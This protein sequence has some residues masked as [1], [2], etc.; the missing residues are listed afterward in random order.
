MEHLSTHWFVYS[1]IN[2]LTHWLAQRKCFEIEC[3]ESI[4]WGIKV[5]SEWS[6]PSIGSQSRSE[7]HTLTMTV[8]S[9]KATMTCQRFHVGVFEGKFTCLR[10]VC[11]PAAPWGQTDPKVEAQKNPEL[12]AVFQESI[13][14]GQAGRGWGMSQ[15]CDQL[16]NDSL[17][18]WCGDNRTV[19]TIN[20]RAPEGWGPG[21]L[22]HQVVNAFPL[23]VVFSVW[24]T[25]E[26]NTKY[27]HQRGAAA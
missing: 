2:L 26:T 27:Y 12:P 16:V 7:I 15:V 11:M 17:M 5:E 4:R 18:G 6:L 20:P 19:N 10:Q 1:S 24:K 25:Q 21:A 22:D 9:D 8:D 3:M 13:F 23:A 14:K